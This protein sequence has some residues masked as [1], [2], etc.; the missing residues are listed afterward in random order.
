[1]AMTWWIWAVIGGLLFVVEL[2]GP[3]FFVIF[4][5]AGALCVSAVLAF[6]P[7][8][9]LWAQ[10]GI[11]SATS[12]LSLLLFRKRLSQAFGQTPSSSEDLLRD[13]ATAADDIAPGA[14]G[15][16]ELRGTPW[17]ARNAGEAPIA[18][19]QRCKVQAVDGLTIQIIPE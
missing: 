11:F 19:G 8:L 4:F 1:M 12:V 17:K 16:A 18:K 9:S 3:G 10:L 6:F 15:K 14:V 5:A 13:I 2:A 7:E